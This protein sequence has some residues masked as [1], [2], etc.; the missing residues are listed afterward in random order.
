MGKASLRWQLRGR[1]LCA[2]TA[3]LAN[4]LTAGVPLLHALAHEHAHTEGD[5][6]H[7]AEEW[8][9]GHDPTDRGADHDEIHSRWLHEECLIAARDGLDTS[10]AI[11]PSAAPAPNGP[12]VEL[13]P[14]RSASALH[15][16]A[17]PA[18]PSARAPPS[19]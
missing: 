15:A 5:V 16:R 19:V 3:L 6:R 9:E 18:S 8:H 12:T 4:L 2:V 10:F 13:A 1:T 14:V 17:P 11:V 7:H